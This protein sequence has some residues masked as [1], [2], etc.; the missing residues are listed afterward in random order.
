MSFE[1]EKLI[2]SVA[3]T[4]ATNA[5]GTDRGTFPTKNL[6]GARVVRLAFG[7]VSSAEVGGTGACRRR[8][9]S[10]SGSRASAARPR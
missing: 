1:Y 3:A 6:A 10:S 8:C 4:C 7:L 9:T 5:A 2:E